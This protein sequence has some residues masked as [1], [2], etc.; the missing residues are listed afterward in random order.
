MKS[1]DIGV[2]A[3]DFKTFE[4][5]GA[6]FRCMKSEDLFFLILETNTRLC[7]RTQPV[8]VLKLFRILSFLIEKCHALNFFGPVFIVFAYF[9]LATTS[10]FHKVRCPFTGFDYHLD[11][12]NIRSYPNAPED[13][14]VK[15]TIW[16]PPR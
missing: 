16:K 15:S 8:D 10:D 1:F 7:G 3:R 6:N 2:E 13:E 14:E 12:A 4:E 5:I 9:Q 11:L